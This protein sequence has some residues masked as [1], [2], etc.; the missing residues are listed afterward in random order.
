MGMRNRT[1]GNTN[2]RSATAAWVSGVEALISAHSDPDED[3]K[4]EGLAMSCVLNGAFGPDDEPG[5]TERRV[6]AD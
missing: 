4:R 6:V 1:F 2:Q 3:R 5:R